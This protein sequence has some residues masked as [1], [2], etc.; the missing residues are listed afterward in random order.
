MLDTV[1]PTIKPKYKL[2]TDGR[3]QT[4]NNRIT[5]KVTD[6][7]SDINT[8]NAYINEQWVLM[9]YDKKTNEMWIDKDIERFGKENLN[10]RVVVSD[11]VGNTATY[12]NVFQW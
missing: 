7:L 8:F 6:N 2:N 3:L 10:V 9:E 11:N 4:I 1:P 5:F 12:T